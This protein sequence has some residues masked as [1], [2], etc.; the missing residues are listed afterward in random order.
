MK[1]LTNILKTDLV[2][3]SL[4]KTYQTI[5]GASLLHTLLNNSINI[6]WKQ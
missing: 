1:I 6:H 5:F 4:K 3:T 2:D